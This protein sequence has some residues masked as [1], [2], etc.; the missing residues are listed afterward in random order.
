VNW[1]PH[2][3]RVSGRDAASTTSNAE[4]WAVTVTVSGVVCARIGAGVVSAR[5]AAIA[6][7]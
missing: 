1:T 2:P 6:K 3:L 7:P 4:H 5:S